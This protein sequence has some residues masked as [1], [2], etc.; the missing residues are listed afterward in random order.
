VRHYE[1]RAIVD[2]A[3]EGLNGPLASV[4]QMRVIHLPEEKVFLG[5][6][7]NRIRVQFPSTSGWILGGPGD[8]N[9]DRKGHVLKAIYPRDG[10]PVDSLSSLSRPPASEE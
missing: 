9:K 7:V 3:L 8:W 1:G 5:L 4:V 6:Y 10:I 2:I